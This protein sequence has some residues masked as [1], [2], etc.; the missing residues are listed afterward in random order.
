MLLLLTFFLI[1]KAQPTQ[2]EV[3]LCPGNR[4]SFNY[5]STSS[6]STGSWLWTLNGRNISIANNTT[7]NWT[8]TGYFTIRVQ[9]TDSCGVDTKSYIVHVIKC[10]PAEIY[11]S[12]AFTPNSDGLNDGWHPIGVNIVNMKFNIWNRWGEKVYEG[13]SMSDKWNGKY[14]GMAADLGTYVVQAFW[15]DINGKVGYYKGFIILIR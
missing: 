8:D 4:T 12:N 7:I 2:Q 10:R 15:K 11:F 14:K 1:T 3:E 6:T 5:W 9:Y 13:H